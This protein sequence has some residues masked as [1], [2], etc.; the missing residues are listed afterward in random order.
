MNDKIIILA[1]SS[2]DRK[3]LF[4]RIKIPYKIIISNYEEIEDP[5]MQAE[6]LTIYLAEGK[7]KAVLDKILKDPNYYEIREK[8][9]FIIAADTLVECSGE[10]LSKTNNKNRAFEILSKLSGKI[11]K[12]ITGVV[13]YDSDS[14]AVSRFYDSTTVKFLNLTESD[15][16]NYLNNCNE[17]QGRAGSYSLQE[18]ASLFVETIEGSPSN[19]IGL[20]MNKIYKELKRFGL[21]LLSISKI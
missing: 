10:T 8:S 5:T 17:W 11:H 6:S 16:W 3:N 15:I 13:I 20:P 12:L 9:Y 14:R 18:R 19:V 2:Q 1:S 21:D 7:M 4:D